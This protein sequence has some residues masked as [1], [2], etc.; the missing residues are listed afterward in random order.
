VSEEQNNDSFE[1][2]DDILNA[3]DIEKFLH[4]VKKNVIYIL[5]FVLVCVLSA[6]LLFIRWTKPVYQSDSLLKLDVQS[7]ATA[8]G[9]SNLGS[10]NIAGMSGEIEILRSNLFLSLV[11][12]AINLDVSYVF[13]GNLLEDERY[14]SSPFVVSYKLKDNGL[15]DHHIDVTIQNSESFLLSY[16]SYSKV[17]KFN[18]PISTDQL[19][20]LVEK[21]ENFSEG[22]EGKYYFV[23]NSDGALINYLRRNLIVNPENFNAK[24][25]RIS[26]TDFNRYKARDLVQAI[27]T[28]YLEYTRNAKNKAVEQKIEFLDEQILLR[29]DNLMDYESYFEN[30]IIDN[31]TQNLSSDIGQAINILI[32]LDSQELRLKR[33]LVDAEFL[34]SH[35]D[36]DS[37]MLSE[38]LSSLNLSGRLGSTLADFQRIKKERDRLL[39]SYNENTFVVKRLD[40]QFGLNEERVAQLVKGYE[41]DIKSGIIGVQNR[42][43]QVEERFF[44]LPSM[45]TEYGK[46]RRF[47]GLEESFQLTL[48]RS[49]MEL[50][51]SRAG[52]VT[53]FIILSPASLP[54][55]PIK[56]E[57][58]IIF[59][60]AIA[61]A[62]AISFVFLLLKYLLN[63][64]ITSVRELERLIRVPLLGTIPNYT[65]EKLAVTKLVITPSSKSAISES[66]RTIRTNMEFLRGSKENR[67]MTVTST[68]SGEGKTFISVNLGAIIAFSDQKV[69]V[70]DLDMRKPKVHLA[71]GDEMGSNGVST[72]LIGKCSLEECIRKT[73]VENLDYIPA[74]PNPPNPSELILHKE[75]SK[76]LESLTQKYDMVILDTPPVGLVTDAVLSMRN[77]DIQIYVMRS[78]YSKR[79][80]VKAIENLR[81]K[82]QFTNLTVVFNGVKKAG[83]SYGNYGYGYGYGYYEE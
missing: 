76:M 13:Q 45:S 33:R 77:S 28:I 24:T 37:S 80:Y 63:N 31:R 44:K 14:H 73:K 48:R 64:T 83:N 78:E 25:L 34:R 81:K 65:S 66:L 69:C 58:K 29:E 41:E 16:G 67:I 52:T 19:N 22:V 46:N 61:L 26:F 18:E 38:Q 53:N 27:D 1:K 74:G 49:K 50:E 40:Q 75:Y 82:N 79:D 4:I 32:S 71:F 21:T 68:V 72:H 23:I 6:Y 7:E 30:F 51:I 39:M 9:F 3:F 35:L 57:K 55:V 2:D 15:Y 11:V 20:L 59:A 54:S 12:D 10:I 62:G 42:R 60:I 17:H 56:P 36:M 47:Y 43:K 70:V 8:L 5:L